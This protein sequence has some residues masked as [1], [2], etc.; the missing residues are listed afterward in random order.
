VIELS[1]LGLSVE[2]TKGSLGDWMGDIDR[3]SPDAC[4]EYRGERWLFEYEATQKNKTKYEEKAEV[5][6][7][8][9]NRTIRGVIFVAATS[10]LKA[11]LAKHFKHR[12][13]VIF[14]LEEIQ[15]GKVTLF[16]KATREKQE[17]QERERERYYEEKKREAEAQLPGLKTKLNVLEITR[18]H[19]R[20]EIQ[21]AERDCENAASA[22]SRFEHGFIKLPGQRESLEEKVRIS[23]RRL[24]ELRNKDWDLSKEVTHCQNE[25]RKL[26]QF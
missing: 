26:E 6:P 24:S 10:G 13:C 22:L 9:S 25:I 12:E 15:Q 18:G 5:L 17:E 19:L 23:N 16:L 8:S 3:I 21:D 4:F 20:D 1:S 14:T 11:I 7:W 2:I